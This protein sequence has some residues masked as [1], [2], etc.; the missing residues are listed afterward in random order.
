VNIFALSSEWDIPTPWDFDT[1]DS[2]SHNHLALIRGADDRAY[3]LCTY[4]STDPTPAQYVHDV[5]Q[6]I[7][8]AA[9]PFALPVGL[10]TRSGAAVVVQHDGYRNWVM[11]M[12]PL[13]AGDHPT[14]EDNASAMRAGVALGHVSRALAAVPIPPATAPTVAFGDYTQLHPGISDPVM[15]VHVAPLSVDRVVKLMELVGVCQAFVAESRTLPR[16]LIHGD[17]APANIMFER[18][19]VTAVLDFECVHA[20]ARIYDL[21]I[22]VSNWC[23]FDASYDR[24]VLRALGRGFCSVVTLEAAESA[25]FFPAVRMV[26]MQRFLYTLGA[27]TTGTVTR[28]QVERA[29]QAVLSYEAWLQRRG[30]EARFDV[31]SWTT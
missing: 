27:Y 28:V 12:T 3:V 29:A 19:A 2:P 18:D 4:D 9:L 11:S 14:L 17:F 25:A 26:R 30:E 8:V 16:Q 20:D 15:N 6:Q 24:R 31:M 22:A 1:I 7:D 10:R 13:Y 21:A 23:T 5:L